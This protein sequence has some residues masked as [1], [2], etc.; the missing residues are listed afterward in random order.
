MAVKLKGLVV[1]AMYVSP[2]VAA[3]AGGYVIVNGKLKRVPPRGPAFKQLQ[4]AVQAVASKR[5]GR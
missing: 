2:G 3:G 1:V 5:G 4:A